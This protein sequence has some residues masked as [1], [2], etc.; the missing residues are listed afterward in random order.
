MCVAGRRMK[1]GRPLDQNTPVIGLWPNQSPSREFLTS[2]ISE[3]DAKEKPGFT[4]LADINQDLILK[5]SKLQS[6]I[7][8]L[9]EE[10]SRI[11]QDC[12]HE[13]MEQFRPIVTSQYAELIKMAA[14]FNMYQYNINKT[15]QKSIQNVRIGFID[16]TVFIT[17]PTT[18]LK[19][20]Q[21]TQLC[22]EIKM[23]WRFFSYSK[24]SFD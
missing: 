6:E 9:K 23:R 18:Y 8:K 22:S 3:W 2:Y 14:K 15:L 1:R 12:Y 20:S 13:A 24:A 10:N 19:N 11:R 7:E 4:H 21:F 16:F 17:S 5:C